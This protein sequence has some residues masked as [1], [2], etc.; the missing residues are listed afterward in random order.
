M[1]AHNPSTATLQVSAD[2]RSETTMNR[3]YGV[4]REWR[5]KKT[6]R[7]VYAVKEK[8]REETAVNAA[9]EPG[10]GARNVSHN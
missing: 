8:K 4:H 5:E 10:A 7:D 6:N 2:R 1:G 9:L 3:R